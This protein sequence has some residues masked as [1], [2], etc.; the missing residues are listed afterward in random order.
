MLVDLRSVAT[1][2]ADQREAK[3]AELDERLQ[4]LRDAVA[5]GHGLRLDGTI[6]EPTSGELVWFDVSIMHTTSRSYLQDE[7]K[8]SR[9]RR[10]ANAVWKSGALMEAY[11]GK[12]DRYAPQPWSSGRC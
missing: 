6:Q 9:E 4:D 1:L 3:L 8:F 7:A 5:D 10:A 12:L 11:Q 2:P